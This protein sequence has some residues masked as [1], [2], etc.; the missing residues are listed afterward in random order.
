MVGMDTSG[1]LPEPQAGYKYVLI[2][3]DYF[4]KWV[5]LYPLKEKFGV[6]VAA[7]IK[8]RATS[9]GTQFLKLWMREVDH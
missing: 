6:K 5:E 7:K 9:A 1:P 4:T 3:T 2:L 8:Y